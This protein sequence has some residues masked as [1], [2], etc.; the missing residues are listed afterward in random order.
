[1]S[2]PQ[3]FV[4]P[5]GRKLEQPVADDGHQGTI[6]LLRPVTEELRRHLRSRI[7][8]L[9]FGTLEIEDK[10]WRDTVSGDEYE[11]VKSFVDPVSPQGAGVS[12]YTIRDGLVCYLRPRGYEAPIESRELGSMSGWQA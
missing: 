2:D 6:G 7:V 8:E 9:D 12:A 3:I 4:A 11:L 1:M 10:T 5:I